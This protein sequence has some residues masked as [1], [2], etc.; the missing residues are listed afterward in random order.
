MSTMMTMFMIVGR[1]YLE[2]YFN[3][4]FK[5]FENCCGECWCCF[6]KKTNFR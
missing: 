2:E 6:F 5:Q 3:S 4:S 1:K